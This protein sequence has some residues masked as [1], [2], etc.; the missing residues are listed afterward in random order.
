MSIQDVARYVSAHTKVYDADEV[1]D[2]GIA[3]VSVHFY[4]VAAVGEPTRQELLDLIADNEKGEWTTIALSRA[5][6][7]PSYIEWGGWIGD[8][9]LALRLLGLGELVGLWQ[10]ITPERMN[11][12]LELRGD[13]A[14]AGYVCNAGFLSV[15]DAMR[16]M[17][18]FT[19]I[20][21]PET[22]VIVEDTDG[23]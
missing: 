19:V 4:Q 7:G 5:E 21:G 16:A 23:A 22:G 20:G 1:A 13:M 18:D 14:G 9:G 12:P 2:T 15:E 6:E 17:P 8:Q 11:V 10:V 3:H